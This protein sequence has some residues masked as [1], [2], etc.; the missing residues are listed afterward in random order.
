MWDTHG[1]DRVKEGQR[2][3][4]CAHQPGTPGTPQ[5]LEELPTPGSQPRD[6]DFW[7]PER[8]RI[9]VCCFKLCCL[10]PFILQLW[11]MNAPSSLQILQIT[12]RE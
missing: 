3:E 2:S 11:E 12:H 4:R 6:T 7:P 10:L 8:G 1:G 9:H 5:E